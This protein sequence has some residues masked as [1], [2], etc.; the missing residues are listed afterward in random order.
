MAQQQSRVDVVRTF[1]SSVSPKRQRACHTTQHARLSTPQ[2]TLRYPSVQCNNTIYVAYIQT[3]KCTYISKLCRHWVL[4]CKTQLP[5]TMLD[6]SSLKKS[7]LSCVPFLH[8]PP[9][10]VE[11]TAPQLAHDKGW[12][13]TLNEGSVPTKVQWAAQ[14]VPA[15]PN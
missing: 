2:Q 12:T 11:I 5:T 6:A 9:Y 14:R 10:P 13:W 4:E 15:H 8:P 7:C 1:A 3:Y